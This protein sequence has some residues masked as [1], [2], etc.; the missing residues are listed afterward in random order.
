MT[1][2]PQAVHTSKHEEPSYL[3]LQCPQC[4]GSL[5]Q[6]RDTSSAE[7]AVMFCTDCCA[8]L[9]CE[10]GIWRALPAHRTCYFARFS[11]DYERIRTAEG[12]GSK[13]STYYLKLPVCDKS[14]INAV[15][16]KIRAR[17]FRY[18]EQSILSSILKRLRPPLRILDL[19]AG[20]CWMSYRL[21]LRGHLPVA[22]DLL[23]N[24]MDGLG[25]AVHYKKRLTTLFPR[26]QAELDNLPFVSGQFDVVIFNASF[27]YSENY[28]RTL[29]EALRCT[30]T[31]G[32]VVIADT[33]WYRHESSGLQ[34]I[35]ERTAAFTARYGIPS[36]SIHSLEYLT[37][38]R[39]HSMEMC[40]GFKWQIFKPFYG[41]RW[42]LRPLLASLKNRREP[43]RFRIYLAPTS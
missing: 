4:S 27:H 41:M 39:L 40:F 23:T 33:P 35:A 29:R 38:D 18:L 36:N 13:N 7:E 17:T 12:R 9:Y 37:D 43:S 31:G 21:A 34:M 2:P 5:A 1:A 14:D 20:N 6:L 42:S 3:M 30:R 28:E 16:W 15:Q 11:K 10:Q 32:V 19:G 25:A 22:V 8:P 24:D 26:V